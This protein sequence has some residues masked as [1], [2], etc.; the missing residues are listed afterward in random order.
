T[1]Y[2]TDPPGDAL[3]VIDPTGRL[4]ERREKDDAGKKLVKPTGLAL[5]QKNRILY[6]VNSGDS[7]ISKT[8]LPERK[9]D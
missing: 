4:R 3:L 6:V 9:G 2:V 1:L 8:K 5:D 7:S